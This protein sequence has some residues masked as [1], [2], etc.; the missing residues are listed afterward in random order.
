V[1]RD[2]VERALQPYERIFTEKGMERAR[3]TLVQV[4]TTD[5][6]AVAALAKLRDQGASGATTVGQVASKPP[7]KPGAQPVV[8]RQKR[9]P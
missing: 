9:K 3:R 8:R 4:F 5:P 6:A 2:V 7:A 1:L